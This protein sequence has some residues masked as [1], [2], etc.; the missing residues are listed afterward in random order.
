M[1]KPKKSKSPAPTKA[2]SFAE[3]R[4]AVCEDFLALDPDEEGIEELRAAI[5][6]CANM[7]ELVDLMGEY[8]GDEVLRFIIEAIVAE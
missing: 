3:A 8:L 2:L 7:V 6:G 5:E 1:K 4:A